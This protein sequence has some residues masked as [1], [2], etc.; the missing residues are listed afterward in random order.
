[1]LDLCAEKFDFIQRQITACG[2]EDHLNGFH[3]SRIFRFDDRCHVE[4]IVGG[5]FVRMVQC[6]GPHGELGAVFFDAHQFDGF[7]AVAVV[8][9]EIVDFHFGKFDFIFEIENRLKQNK[10]I[11]KEYP[12]L[13]EKINVLLFFARNNDSI[14]KQD[15]F[16]KRIKHYNQIDIDNLI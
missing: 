9:P 14:A 16:D 1:M 8:P 3:R 11:R 13:K 7:D 10:N 2:G 12:S 4:G 15:F 5:L 6:D